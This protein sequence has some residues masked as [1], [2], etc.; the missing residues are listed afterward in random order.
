MFVTDVTGQSEKGPD[1]CEPL[2]LT[3]DEIVRLIEV[4]SKLERLARG[5]DTE[6]HFTKIVVNLVSDPGDEE[7]QVPIN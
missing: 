1:R 2:N 3:P 7:D 4:G 6:S 5:E